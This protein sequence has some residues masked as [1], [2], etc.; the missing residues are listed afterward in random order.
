MLS[1]RD[2]DPPP[3]RNPGCS[4]SL[5]RPMSLC[6]GPLWP[7]RGPTSLAGVRLVGDT[8]DPRWRRFSPL[9]WQ[10]WGSARE[11]VEMAER[12]SFIGSRA[13]PRRSCCMR[14]CQ[15]N[16]DLPRPCVNS[17]R[18]APCAGSTSRN[19]RSWTS[20]PPDG[21]HGQRHGAEWRFTWRTT[22]ARNEES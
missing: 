6:V 7:T 17:F 15:W 3:T 12:A 20:G 9:V 5:P 13:S 8:R 21:S 10:F 19:A 14:R 11:K 16:R 22:R 18:G 4:T 2:A 1:I